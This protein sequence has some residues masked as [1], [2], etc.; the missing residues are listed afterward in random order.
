[1]VNG[2]L[3]KGSKVVI[4]RTLRKEMLKRADK[5]HL[6]IAKCKENAKTLMFWP[7]MTSEIQKIISHCV[8]YKHMRIINQK[9]RSIMMRPTLSQ[10]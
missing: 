4:P 2:V 8:T 5:G 9:K 3:L 7:G 1:M 10:P 6:G